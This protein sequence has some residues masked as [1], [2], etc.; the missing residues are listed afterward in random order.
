MTDKKDNP[1]VIA[2][3]PLIFLSG[4]VLGGI[5]SW[6]YPA[7][8]LPKMVS[9]V[10]GSLLILAGL[11]IIFTIWWQ[12]RKAQTNIEPWKPTTVILE[13]GLYGFTRNPIYG[14]MIL[15][16][17]GAACLFNSIWFLPFLPFV[18]LGIHFGVILREEKYLEGKF[19]EAYLDYKSRVRRWI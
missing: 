17:L 3:P 1:K 18:L 2:P 5:V 8:I 6:F 10:A 12:M 14:A 11:G 9:L 4:L 19:G 7:P 15:V 13:S 16:Y